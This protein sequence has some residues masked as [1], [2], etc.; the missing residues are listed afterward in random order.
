M[1][2][3]RQ[4]AIDPRAESQRSVLRPALARAWLVRAMSCCSD[5]ELNAL[6]LQPSVAAGA[7][8]TPIELA[9]SATAT[10]ETRP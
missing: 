10:A 9:T 1:S 8:M 3:L 6:A 7:A 2:L 4:R 5:A